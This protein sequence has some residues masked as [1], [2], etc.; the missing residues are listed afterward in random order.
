MPIS[1]TDPALTA[2]RSGVLRSGAGRSGW[3][4]LQ[5]AVVPLKAL[6]GVARSGATRSGYVSAKT[7]L[8]IGGTQFAFNHSEDIEPGLTV[9][10]RVLI[11]SLGIVDSLDEQPNTAQFRAMGFIP[12]VGSEVIL[13]LGS[14][15]NLSR[16]YAGTIL[17]TSQSFLVGVHAHRVFD[18][19]LID[20]T[21]G[22]NR[23]KVSGHYTGSFSNIF[24]ALAAEYA[25]D[26]TT[27][28]V[29][30]GLPTVD[31][32]ITFTEEDLTNCFTQLAR[33]GGLHWLAD[34]TKD[35]SLRLT[36]DPNITAP[37][38][39]NRVNPLFLL[40]PPLTVDRDLSPFI[41]R[42][43]VEGGGGVTLEA[44]A[45]GET[46][47]PVSAGD[48]YL[49]G[50]GTVKAGPQR[51]TY[52]GRVLGGAG[53]LVG[54][55]AAPSAAPAVALA[56]GSGIES[57]VHE[58]AVV[59]VTAAGKSLPSPRTSI[60]VGTLAAP[61]TAPTAG[62]PTVG[63]GPSPGEH[64][65]AVTFQTATG[66]TT[67]G[68]VV[69]KA[70]T[71]TAAPTSAPT[72]TAVTGLGVDSGV[73]D[74]AY[75][76]TTT[77]G[78]TTPT[79]ISGSVTTGPVVSGA[80]VDPSSAP[81]VALDD[82]TGMDVGTFQYAATFT[83]AAGETL[84]S[85]LSSSI[86]TTETTS[87]SSFDTTG[88]GFVAGGSLDI[89][90]LYQWKYTFRR[91]SDGLETL[92]SPSTGSIGPVPSVNRTV[93]FVLAN[94][95]SPPS[96][97]TR[98]FYRT[99]GGGSTFKEVVGGALDATYFYDGSDDSTLTSAIPTT[100]ETSFR[101][102]TVSSIP[103]GGVGTTGRKVYR[104]AAG[105]SQ[106]KLLQ[107]IANNTSTQITDSSPDSSLGAN[108]PTSN[109][110]A[111]TV[112]Y[113]RVFLTGIANGGADVTGKKLY[114][115]SGG[116][117][118]KLVTTLGAAV[119]T[120]TD[121]TPNASLG[122]VVPTVNTAYLQRIPLSNLPIGGALVT[123]RRLWG[124]AAGASQ[125]KLIT[126]LNTTD[127]TYT[128]TTVDGS[129]GANIHITNTATANQ[130]MLSGIPI[131]A[132]SVT[133]REIHR[134]TTGGSQLKLQQTI[135]N[136]VDTTA[137]DSLSDASL[138]ANAPSSDTSGLTQPDGVVFPGSTSLISA[139]TAWA[140]AGGGWAIIGNGQQVIRYTAVSGSLI[141]GIPATGIGAITAP[142]QYNSTITQAPQ[143]TGIPTTGPGS[144]R[145][146]LVR[147]QDVNLFVVVDD[148]AS[149]AALA[150]LLTTATHTHDGIIEAG[151]QDRRLAAAEA[152]DRGEAYLAER[153]QINVEIRY[154]TR[155]LNTRAGQI[156][157]VN[158]G[159]PTNVVG[160]FIIQSVTIGHFHPSQFPVCSVTA[161]N[162]KFSFDDL[163]RLFGRTP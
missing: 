69:I 152:T 154:A 19:Q 142:V 66:E 115:R 92:P 72:P 91:T 79:P 34:Y 65:Y 2:A 46:I 116:A 12:E 16:L 41:S 25:P 26:Y 113:N 139:G 151:I 97:F 45:V 82:G 110:T 42:V 64:Q 146:A 15:N 129:L 89:G 80:L 160:D 98:V 84:P 44:V 68:P 108:A 149:R 161:S 137:T 127:T 70:T 87:P 32:G 14:V 106:L 9:S 155:D 150:A 145:Y 102:V 133:A 135:A 55:G 48:W 52:T 141:T 43:N 75:T 49:P 123:G 57:G 158:L 22:L 156:V 114:R 33:R 62:T 140:Q 109:T 78:E 95:N 28:G 144:I 86:T 35:L 59:F 47:L 99:D 104:T 23:R 85:P 103:I 148:L 6:S 130:V 124:T 77:I 5:G 54:P 40:N 24:R 11:D 10:P 58:Y 18:C 131:G 93:R 53:S 56:S 107:A 31:G 21:W 96:G 60:T 27:R 71:L 120:Y 76:H 38:L 30:D 147:G 105:G 4:V 13:T 90:A 134:T 50:G 88:G 51:I 132:G 112:D 128:V 94:L 36:P 125:L 138:G 111:S 74:Y 67:A 7:F 136:N 159:H 37:S 73:H 100:N 126:T 143:L 1:G 17:R 119:T 83:N 163:L 3:P 118:L 29:E 39:V 157:S 121:S 101:R 63:T 162:R 122:A 61:A 81:A 117:G 8:S 153:N 20:Y